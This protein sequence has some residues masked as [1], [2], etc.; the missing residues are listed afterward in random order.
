[1]RFYY[2]KKNI[3]S[4]LQNVEDTKYIYRYGIMYKFY[5]KDDRLNFEIFD[6]D[7]DILD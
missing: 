3:E 7:L 5:V 1:M 4:I 2:E 6:E